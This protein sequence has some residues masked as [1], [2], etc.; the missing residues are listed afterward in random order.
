MIKNR[1]I[2]EI[3]IN[4]RPFRFECC[5]EALLEEAEKAL[6]EMSNYIQSRLDAIK[7]VQPASQEEAA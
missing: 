2:I 1:A 7:P 5:Q 6:K 4:G 3:E